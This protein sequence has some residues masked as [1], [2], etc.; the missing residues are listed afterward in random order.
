MNEIAALLS[1][2]MVMV[3]LCSIVPLGA[4]AILGFIVSLLQAAT[5]I[6][7]QTVS[8]L[9]KFLAISLLLFLGGGT[10][11]NELVRFIEELFLLLPALGRG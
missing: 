1:H 4:S 5:Q 6:Q 7:E 10:A 3:L 2:A 11:G 9:V 8:F